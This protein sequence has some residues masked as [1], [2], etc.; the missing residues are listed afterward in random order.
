MKKHNEF[1]ILLHDDDE[2]S[3]IE[4]IPVIS[5]ETLQEWPLSIVE[6]IIFS[7]GTSRIYKAFHNLPIETEFYRIVRSQ[8]IPKIFY[9]YSDDNQ[10]HW[11]LLEDVVGQPPDNLNEEQMLDIA[12]HARKII[13]GIGSAEPY[14]YNL[15]ER[16]YHNFLNSTIGLLRK[17]YQEDKLKKV[18]RMAIDRIEESLSHSEVWCIVRGKCALLHGDL[19][20]NNILIRPDGEMIIIDWQSIL[21]GP[22]EIDIYNLLANQDIDPVQIAGIGPEI[23]RSALIIKWLADCIDCWLPYWAKFYDEKI[24]D[25]EKHIQNVVKNN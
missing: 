4:R 1:E 23:L 7:D 20:C 8:Y 13:C 25:I 21:F 6:R 2:L 5:R 17:L 12:F 18:D 19:K 14:R 9:N 3:D 22:E 16:Y 10:H 11:L 15:S 24:A